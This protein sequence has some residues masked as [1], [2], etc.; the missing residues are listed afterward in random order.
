MTDKIS[1]Q[2]ELHN[3]KHKVVRSFASPWTKSI[4]VSITIIVSMFL[5]WRSDLHLPGESVKITLA[6]FILAAVF[7]MTEVIPLYVTSLLILVLEL[8]FLYPQLLREGFAATRVDFMSPFFSD[9]I[10]LFLGGL[11]L[12]QAGSKYRIDSMVASIVLRA[13]GGKPSLVLLGMMVA[14]A[15][16]SMWMSNTATTAMMLIIAV[17][18]T[19]NLDPK[20]KKFK[21]ALFL[22]IPFSCNIGGMGSPIGTPPNAIA[23]AFLEKNGT[24]ISFLDWM[25]AV[26]PLVII[27]LLIL[28]GI[29]LLF[30]PFPKT[31]LPIS[32]DT[33]LPSGWKSKAVVIIFF[34]TVALWLSGDIHGLSSGTIAL[35]SS[36]ALLSTGILDNKDFR[37]ISWDVLFLVGGGLSLGVAMEKSGFSL[38][39]VEILSLNTLGFF[40]LLVLFI[41]LGSILTTFMSNT[42]TANM[43]I[44]LAI[45]LGH[46][47]SPIVIGISLAVSASMALPVS[48]PPNAIAYYSG[49]IKLT[50][51]FRTG[52]TI[53][54]ISAIMIIITATTYWKIL[55]LY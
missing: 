20:S 25:I 2:N 49:E 46:S 27:L 9:I 50:E 40:P 34:A 17:A 8:T 42:A 7:W 5:L 32:G 15:N 31:S 54:I 16:L 12:A 48:T 33:R 10:M 13:T 39:L 26:I 19:R 36:I 6:L 30:F 3:Q 29:L 38:W 45:S 14:G 18:I 52:I 53:S 41:L 22:G 55:H 28:W 4:F 1:S 44:P 43:L 35:F 47:T 11:L 24:A 51:M 21:K 23:V 37:G